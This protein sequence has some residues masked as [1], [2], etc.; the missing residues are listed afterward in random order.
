VFLTSGSHKIPGAAFNFFV[1]DLINIIW[2]VE[3][4]VSEENQMGDT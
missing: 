2:K 3:R 1:L 4:R